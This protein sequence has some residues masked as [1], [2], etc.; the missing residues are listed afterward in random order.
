LH[1]GSLARA[2]AAVAAGL[3]LAAPAQAET[4]FHARIGARFW[5]TPRGEF[6]R[7]LVNDQPIATLHISSGGLTPAQR[8][9]TIK[10]RLIGLVDADLTPTQVSLVPLGREGW[11]IRGQGARIILVSPRDGAAQRQ[12]AR[13]LAQVWAKA[14]KTRLAEP[15]LS[16]AKGA[17]LVPFGAA[18][19]VAVGG[20]PAPRTSRWRQGT[21]GSARR[22]MTP[23]AAGS[24]CAGW[25]RGR[26][27]FRS[28]R[29]GPPCR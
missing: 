28:W 5:A 23:S 16:L 2:V 20:R 18:R 8:A 10:D 4:T 19:T 27:R 7:V 22:P 24:R 29:L 21:A 25:D 26:R 15:P 12:T 11:E 3:T 17:I 6:A 13:H 9:V 14:L 1:Y